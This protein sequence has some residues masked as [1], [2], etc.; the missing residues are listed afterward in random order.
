MVALAIVNNKGRRN[1]LNK[2]KITLIRMTYKGVD[3]KMPK[4]SIMIH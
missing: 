4:L 3:C 1:C 2:K